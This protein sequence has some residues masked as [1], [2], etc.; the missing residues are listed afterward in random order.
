MRGIEVHSFVVQQ[1][2]IVVQ[3]VNEFEDLIFKKEANKK[4]RKKKR[5]E[6]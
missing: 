1:N 3:H 6:S 2:V 4:M 5:R